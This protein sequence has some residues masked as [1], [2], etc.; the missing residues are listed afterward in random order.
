MKLSPGEKS[1]LVV[2][3]SLF[4]MLKSLFTGVKSVFGKGMGINY[5]F[6]THSKPGDG[7]SRM[8]RFLI[9]EG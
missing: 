8:R 7:V 4:T 1:L 2:A 3:K 9:G 6:S 5:H